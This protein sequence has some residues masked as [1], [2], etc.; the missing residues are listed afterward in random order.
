MSKKSE[1]KDVGI[2][3]K[4]D[5]LLALGTG[6]ADLKKF[7]EFHEYF[8]AILE[9]KIGLISSE[10]SPEFVRELLDIV[11]ENRLPD[12]LSN[13]NSTNEEDM[14]RR[15]KNLDPI[16]LAKTKQPPKKLKKYL[17]EASWAYIHGLFLSCRSLCRSVLETAIKDVLGE[18][19]TAQYKGY[20]CEDLIDED[21]RPKKGLQ[22]RRFGRDLIDY[23]K[24]EK[25]PNDEAYFKADCIRLKGNMAIHNA[26][27]KVININEE[28]ETLEVLKMTRELLGYLYS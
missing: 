9:Y 6:P 21:R 2:D 4:I 15:W 28:Q 5:R 24:D 25:K 27:T 26:A 16:V 3:T 13:A 20:T 19:I 17:I 11:E 8:D 22:K 23:W 7:P 14:T 18:E 1:T 10:R 12:F